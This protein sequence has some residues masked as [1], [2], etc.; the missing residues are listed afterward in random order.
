MYEIM[1][2]APFKEV[3]F[4]MS[5]LASVP[6][7]KRPIIPSD[8]SNDNKYLEYIKLMKKCWSNEQNNRPEFCTIIDELQKMILK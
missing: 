2:G 4:K 1:F 5:L 6:K 8:V 7:G 3:S